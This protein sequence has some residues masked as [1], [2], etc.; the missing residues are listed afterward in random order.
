MAT[1]SVTVHGLGKTV[2]RDI[3]FDEAVSCSEACDMAL[4]QE[5]EPV[6]MQNVTYLVNGSRADAKDLLSD[7]DSLTAMSILGGG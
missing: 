5:E 2:K 4:A 1:V 7:G 6:F 3:V